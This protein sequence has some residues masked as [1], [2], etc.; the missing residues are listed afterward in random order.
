MNKF[1]FFQ[2]VLSQFSVLV[3]FVANKQSKTN[4]QAMYTESAAVS[5]TDGGVRSNC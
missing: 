4:N 3:Y 2:R 5:Y 1:S